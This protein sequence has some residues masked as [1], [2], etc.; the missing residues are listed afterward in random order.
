MAPLS[1]YPIL[2]KVI[3]FSSQRRVRGNQADQSGQNLF[4]P[5]FGKNKKKN[6][7]MSTLFISGFQKTPF[8]DEFFNVFSTTPI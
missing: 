1:F 6:Q 8:N 2:K 7:A 3:W 4:R 5:F